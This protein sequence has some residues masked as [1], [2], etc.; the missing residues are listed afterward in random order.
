[1]LSQKNAN[2]IVPLIASLFASLFA[3]VVASYIALFSVV[4]LGTFIA[5]FMD[6][7]F[8][9]LLATHVDILLAASMLPC[10]LPSKLLTCVCVLLTKTYVWRLNCSLQCVF[11]IPCV[12]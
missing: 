10:C 4:L 11:G 3:I 6:A 12:R 2:S 8:V 5:P 7:L 9:I 1:M